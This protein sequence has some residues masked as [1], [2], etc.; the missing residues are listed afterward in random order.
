MTT[1][2]DSTMDREA[3]FALF[4]AQHRERAVSIAWRLCGDAVLADELAQEAFVQAWHRLDGFRNEAALSTW[5]H[6]IL[7][8]QVSRRRRWQRVRDT[9][10]H[11]FS[12]E[13]QP[14]PSTDPSL[15]ERLSAAMDQL[16]DAQ[17]QA[18]LLVTLE[19]FTV[20]EASAITGRAPGTLKSHLHRART[21][22]RDELAD[23]WEEA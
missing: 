4:V 21:T 1:S 15:R 23:V 13:P 11:W 9:A 14:P 20:Q 5:F 3:R 17:R 7:V 18:F 8:R 10:R 2:N 6:R 16:T 22:L 12:T 19:G